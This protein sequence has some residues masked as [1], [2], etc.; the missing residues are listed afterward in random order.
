MVLFNAAAFNSLTSAF[1][2]HAFSDGRFSRCALS[3][4]G[5]AEPSVVNA[6]S[7]W[8]SLS[9]ARADSIPEWNRIFCRE[10]PSHKRVSSGIT[11]VESHDLLAWS[12]WVPA[13]QVRSDRTL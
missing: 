7:R 13:R 9:V 12:D 3:R 4:E 1:L 6:P 8:V 11:K 2:L 10:L 5:T